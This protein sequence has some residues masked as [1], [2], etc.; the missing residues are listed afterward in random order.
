M[1]SFPRQILLLLLAGFT[2]PKAVDGIPLLNGRFE[3]TTDVQELLNLALDAADM[4]EADDFD[5]K[6][7]IYRDGVQ[8][9]NEQK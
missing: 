9:A 1:M 7:T 3:T 5:S 6:K 4:K 8:R 2:T